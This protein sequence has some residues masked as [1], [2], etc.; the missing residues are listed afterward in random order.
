MEQENKQHKKENTDAPQADEPKI[1]QTVAPQSDARTSVDVTA[2]EDSET[3]ENRSKLSTNRS[4]S[5]NDCEDRPMTDADDPEDEEESTEL[6]EPIFSVSTALDGALQ[7]EASESVRG[8][9]S[10]VLYFAALGAL[11]LMLGALI[12]QTVT[13][14]TNNALYI[15]LVAVVL[16]YTLYTRIFGGKVAMRRWEND[17]VRRYQTSALH[18]TADFY[19]LVMTQTVR[20][21]DTS[22]EAG[23]SEILRVKET[24]RL[25]LLQCGKQKWLFVAKDGFTKGTPEEFRVFM[26]EKTGGN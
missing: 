4:E 22:L 8:T 10:N 7:Q 21:N 23:Y 2:A 9:M 6:P 1:P 25:F 5:L 18:L 24:E 14:G 3:I 20:E 19:D 16:A 12:W 11:V 13:M 15:A 26:Q 17:L